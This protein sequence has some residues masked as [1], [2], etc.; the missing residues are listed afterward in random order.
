M[1]IV[2]ISLLLVWYM[3]RILLLVVLNQF[4]QNPGIGIYIY[5]HFGAAV[6]QLD[7]GFFSQQGERISSSEY[8]FSSLLQVHIF[9]NCSKFVLCASFVSRDSLVLDP[10]C[11]FVIC[12]L[13][14]D[15]KSTRLRK[16]KILFLVTP[17]LLPFAVYKLCSQFESWTI[18]L[19]I[20]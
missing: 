20:S 5:F 4:L 2:E 16:E 8:N 15:R 14:I 7:M 3:T 6:W 1:D 10:Y 18:A 19:L 11:Q 13:S 12:L 17:F 9:L